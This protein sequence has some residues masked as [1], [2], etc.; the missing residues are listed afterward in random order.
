MRFGRIA[1]MRDLKF[2][3]K[4]EFEGAPRRRRP[5]SNVQIALHSKICRVA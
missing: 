2:D 3:F 1:R 5:D 4:S